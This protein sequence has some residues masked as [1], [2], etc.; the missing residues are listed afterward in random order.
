MLSSLLLSAIMNGRSPSLRVAMYSAEEIPPLGYAINGPNLPPAK[1][2]HTMIETRFDLKEGF[3]HS[4]LNLSSSLLNTQ[5]GFVSCPISTLL[6]SDHITF[7]QSASVHSI[8]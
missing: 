4:G 6:S 1:H 7:C 8:R 3:R 5:R 2:P